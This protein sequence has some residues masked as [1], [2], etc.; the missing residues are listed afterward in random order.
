MFP[1]QGAEQCVKIEEVT[2]RPEM[3]LVRKTHFKGPAWLL[4]GCTVEYTETQD[5]LGENHGDLELGAATH[6]MK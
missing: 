1:K 4:S 2:W 6:W 5:E 3:R